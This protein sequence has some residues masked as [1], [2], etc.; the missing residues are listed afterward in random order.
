MTMPNRSRTL[1]SEHSSSPNPTGRR[2]RGP[3]HFVSERT[4]AAFHGLPEGDNH[5]EIGDLLDAVG[6]TAGWSPALVDHFQLLLGWTRPVDWLPGS[7]PIV[8]LSV[9]ETAF[10][11][12]ISTSQVRRNEAAMHRLGAIAWKDSPNHRRYGTRNDAGEIEDAWGV[13]L[14]PA[15]ALVPELRRLLERRS[16]D[17]TR[18]RHLRHAVAGARGRL[19]AAIETALAAARLDAASAEA[20]RRLVVGCSR[21]PDCRHTRPLAAR[22]GGP[23][24][25]EGAVL[26]ARLR[27]PCFFEPR[28]DPNDGRHNTRLRPKAVRGS[29]F[30]AVADEGKP[31]RSCL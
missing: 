20:W 16:E 6:A 27:P 12:G 13:N 23:A 29:L 8:W 4:A 21:F 7:R 17:R 3:A 18:Q 11:L 25:R 1:S 22:K 31:A 30:G 24:D 9:A 14:A 19:V 2:P 28:A 5:H 10:R 15:A 26:Q